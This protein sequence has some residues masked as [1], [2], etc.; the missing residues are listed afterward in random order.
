MARELDVGFG[1]LLSEPEDSMVLR[2]GEGGG[3]SEG[4]HWLLALFW[5]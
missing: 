1:R 4:R 3:M 5:L 2:G